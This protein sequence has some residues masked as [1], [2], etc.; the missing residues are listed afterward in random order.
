MGNMLDSPKTEREGELYTS[1]TGISIGVSSM[2][3]WRGEME[4]AHVIEDLRSKPDH[5]IVGV[6]DGHAGSKAAKFAARHITNTLES[7]P[8][9][10]EY[11]IDTQTTTN[12]V[13]NSMGTGKSLKLLGDALQQTFQVMDANL[14]YHLEMSADRSGC[15]AVV[16]IVT[17]HHIICANAGDSRCVAGTNGVAKA[18][19]EDHK[20]DQQFEKKR[21][22]AAGGTTIGKR[23][24][25]ELAVSRALGDFSFKNRR[26]L[27]DKEQKVSCY[28]DIV[29]HE[30]SASDDVLIL[31]CDGLWDVMSKSEAIS[32]ACEMLYTTDGGAKNAKNIADSM[33]GLALDKGSR[34][35]ISAIVVQLRTSS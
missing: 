7:T 2:Q 10:K 22:I 6:F 28:P 15:T 16:A 19:S 30:R 13:E 8:T 32:T 4:D 17:P 34:D 21:I 11:I 25:G 3:G 29:I 24:D 27:S 12:C 1:S 9:W 26:D 33:I 35:N 18:L 14:R 31:A 5:V 20:P 23:V